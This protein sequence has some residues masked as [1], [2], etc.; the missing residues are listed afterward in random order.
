M[1]MTLKQKIRELHNH[2]FEIKCGNEYINPT[3]APGYHP[4]VLEIP[5][6]KTAEELAEDFDVLVDNTWFTYDPLALHLKIYPKGYKNILEKKKL[7][8]HQKWL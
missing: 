7:N 5:N 4:G 6:I 1:I 2:V 8:K 3:L